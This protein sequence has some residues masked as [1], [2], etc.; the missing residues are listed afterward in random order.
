MSIRSEIAEA[1]AALAPQHRDL[2]EF[3][4]EEL[5]KIGAKGGLGPVNNSFG[6]PRAPVGTLSSVAP[7]KALLRGGGGLKLPSIGGRGS[8][9]ALPA[10]RRF[11]HGNA[12]PDSTA[13]IWQ[14]PA[15]NLL[16]RN[17]AL[18]SPISP[19]KGVLGASSAKSD[20]KKKKRSKKK[21]KAE[22]KAA[23]TIQKFVRKKMAETWAA[24]KMQR[25]IR[26][27]LCRK[28]VEMVKSAQ[29]AGVMVAI[30]GTKQ[31]KSGT[32]QDFDGTIYF[33][34]VD[35]EGTWWQVVEQSEWNERQEDLENIPVLV[36]Q[37]GTKLQDLGT[38]RKNGKFKEYGHPNRKK[39]T[40]NWKEIAGG[41][42]QRAKKG[43]KEK[44]F[45]G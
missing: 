9:S 17:P 31:G 19:A 22:K 27:H 28:Y 12:L 44:L 34:A 35:A 33:F 13:N 41:I 36:C 5:R 23:K 16:A 2:N 45:G 42:W 25:I 15:D 1:R 3:K 6:R 29:Q 38:K 26:G 32:Y 30:K 10:L 20:K 37:K 39:G 4:Q 43:L 7:P 14:K 24:K 11:G 40:Q 8:P 18:H 21:K